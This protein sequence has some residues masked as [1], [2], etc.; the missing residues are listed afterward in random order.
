MC[1]QFDIDDVCGIE[2]KWQFVRLKLSDLHY[3]A[4]DK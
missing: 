1:F 3:V 2:W 4:K